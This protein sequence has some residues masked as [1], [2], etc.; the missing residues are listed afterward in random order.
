MF[1]SESPFASLIHISL[2]SQLMN[3]NC[4]HWIISIVRR[5]LL[6]PPL[7]TTP[8]PP[9]TPSLL[10]TDRLSASVALCASGQSDGH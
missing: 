7:L 9:P 2:D 4:C 8:P 3:R 5:L 10:L 6:L 1:S